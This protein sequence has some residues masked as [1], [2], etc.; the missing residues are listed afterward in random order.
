MNRISK[1]KFAKTAWEFHILLAVTE[2][3]FYDAKLTHELLHL[4]CTHRN[5]LELSN[6]V[7]SLIFE[8]AFN[9]NIICMSSH[10][11]GLS[12]CLWCQSVRFNTR[13]YSVHTLVVYVSCGIDCINMD[14]GF[15][16]NFYRRKKL[17]PTI[18]LNEIATVVGFFLITS[19]I[20]MEMSRY[21]SE[22]NSPYNHYHRHSRNH[23]T[24]KLAPTNDHLP[25]HFHS[26]QVS[27]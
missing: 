1:F 19:K 25:Q 21:I 22:L 11:N 23:Q 8:N 4:F 15:P 10:S 3:Y 6:V 5:C 2:F 17:H 12:N 14:F 9:M 18:Q 13:V 26:N 24:Q 27:V 7:R 16:L 20:Y